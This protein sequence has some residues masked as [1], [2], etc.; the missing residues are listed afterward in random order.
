MKKQLAEESGVVGA[1]VEEVWRVLL[2]DLGDTWAHHPGPTKESDGYWVAYQGG[3]WYRCEWSAA[4]HP[5]GTLVVQRVFNVAEWGA[6]AVPLANKF[7][8]GFERNNR[9]GFAAG[10]ARI[11]ERLGCSTRLA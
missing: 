9:E 2:K 5:E 6:W 8:I 11:G 4:A 10:L 1:P 7:F 3:W